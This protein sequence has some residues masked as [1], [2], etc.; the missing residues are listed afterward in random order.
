M[1]KH[2]PLENTI[3]LIMFIGTSVFKYIVGKLY[4]MYDALAYNVDTYYVGYIIE[5]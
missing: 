3:L 1:Q 2:Y 5:K 4:R